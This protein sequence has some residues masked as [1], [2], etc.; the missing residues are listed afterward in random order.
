MTPSPKKHAGRQRKTPYAASK[1]IEKEAW[2]RGLTCIAGVDEVGRGP[3]AGPVVAAAVIMPPDAHIRHVTDSKA[4]WPEEREALAA[5]IM[6]TATCWAVGIVPAPMIDA[7]NILRATYLAMREALR[8]LQPAP[9]LILVD[10]WA[11]P[12]IEFPQQNLI[13]GDKRC[14]SIAAAS[15]V[16]KVHR[17]RIMRHLDTIYPQY[18]FASH[19]GYA[20]AQHLQAINEHGPC[21][22]HR[23]SFSPFSARSQETLDFEDEEEEC[24]EN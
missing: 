20:C 11:L 3:L 23:L 18:G 12:D 1:L 22:V 6:R 19:K 16:A 17:D 2:A 5:E 15:I 21:P 24:L 4:L 14:Y 10:G 13:G 8:A 9:E 7:C